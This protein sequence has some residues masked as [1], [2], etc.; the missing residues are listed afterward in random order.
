M[1][2]ELK[3]TLTIEAQTRGIDQ[4]RA[5]GQALDGL[6]KGATESNPGLAKLRATL[7]ELAQQQQLIAQFTRLK[8]E[9]AATATE[10]R[11]TQAAVASAARELKAKQAATQAAAAAEQVAAA[12]TAQARAHHDALK[13]AVALATDELKQLRA[14]ARN[15]GGA[16]GDLAE[17]IKTTQGQLGVLRGESQ[18]AGAQVKA[19]AAEQRQLGA[20]TRDAATEQGVAEKAMARAVAGAQNAKTGYEAQRGTLHSLRQA[21]AQTGVSTTQLADAQR[22]IV[23]AVDQARTAY[24]S[25]MATARARGAEETRLAS[26]IEATKARMARAAQEQLAAEKADHAEAAAAL[27]RRRQQTEAVAR[28]IQSA[29]DSLRMRSASQIQAEIDGVNHSLEVLRSTGNLS[30]GELARASE[31]AR[32]RVA[33]LNREM[34]GLSPTAVRMRE[35]IE[36]IST[37][38][39]RMQRL[40]FAWQGMMAAL[41]RGRE[42]IETADRYKDIE[43]RIDLVNRTAQGFNVTMADMVA[44]SKRTYSGIEGTTQ[45]M[46]SLARAGAELDVGQ[47]AVLRLTETINKANQVAGQSAAAADAAVVQL[48][49]GLQSGVLRGE[50]FN[51]MM[52]QSPRLAKALADGLDVPTSALRAMAGEG[53]LTTDVIIEALQSQ[54]E[55]IDAEFARLPLTVGRALTVLRTSWMNFVGGLD[56]ASGVTAGISHL[57]VALS[58]NLE[59]LGRIVAVVGE[60]IVAHFA[61]KAV[62]G[63]RAYMASQVAATAS[64]G[65]LSAAT[66]GMTAALAAARTAMMRFLPA[67]I[68]VLIGELIYWLY[69]A[70]TGWDELKERARNWWTGGDKSTERARNQIAA[71]EKSLKA[72]AD[73]FEPVAEAARDALEDVQKRIDETRNTATTAAG[74][75]GTAYSGMTDLLAGKLDEQLAAIERRYEQERAE[76]EA[77]GASQRALIGEGTRLLTAALLAET[78]ARQSAAAETLRLIDEEG[79]ARR[80]AAE[81]QADTDADRQVA[82]RRVENEI[83]AT[84]KGA[85]EQALES[86]RRHVDALNAE[87][88]RHLAEVTRI[89][90]AKQAL[91]LSVEDR[92]R[93]IQRGTMSEAEALEDRRAQVAEKQAAARQALSQGE[94]DKSRALA[95]QAMELSA[96]VAGAQTRDA[97]DSAAA[98]RTV[99][100]AIQDMLSSEKLMQEALDAEAAAHRQAAEKAGAARTEIGRTISE[101]EQQVNA[102]AEALQDGLKLTLE[103]DTEKLQKALDEVAALAAEKEVLVSVEADL[104]AAEQRIEEYAALLA[105]GKELPVDADFSAAQAALERF[106]EWAAAQ[107]KVALE[108]QTEDAQ[109]AIEKVQAGIE[110]LA[111]IRTESRHVVEHNAAAVAGEI[112]SLNG[113][114]THSTHTITIQRVEANAAG[115]LIGRAAAGV[116][117]L[118]GGGRAWPWM[119]EGAVPG[120]GD[121]DSVA[122]TLPAG[123]YVVRKAAVAHYGRSGLQDMITRATAAAGH[124]ASAARRA[125]AGVSALLMPGEQV[126]APADVARLGVQFFDGLNAMTLPPAPQQFAGGGA[127]TPMIVAGSAE[128]DVISRAWRRLFRR[129][130]VTNPDD[131]AEFRKWFALLYEPEQQSFSRSTP[132]TAGSAALEEWAARMEGYAD[133]VA[134][135]ALG[136]MRRA[137]DKRGGETSGTASRS[138]SAAPEIAVRRDAGDP[139]PGAGATAGRRVH[140]VVDLARQQHTFD[141]ASERD[142][143]AVEMMLRSLESAAKV[144]T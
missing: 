138:S 89:E 58:N 131:E 53:K 128:S 130:A 91:R 3:T 13:G 114:D 86:Y 82:A 80:Q 17:R 115:G 20:A 25:A 98:K 9:T 90:S 39:A 21:L 56:K 129:G 63:L 27:E 92:I 22:R 107:G 57:I 77:S 108:I 54:A 99:D 10:M 94:F 133:Q 126:I 68:I 45:L 23:G 105:A 48:I 78:T 69:K 49:Q 29:L 111:D 116:L 97:K 51:S 125:T 73:R 2:R 31:R 67:A 134:G 142:A 35:G 144:A 11:Q 14:E 102:L 71:L 117:R 83:L 44:L 36:S 112:D 37:S 84:R 110:K 24:I 15:A 100:R 12:A 55:A 5:A 64:T 40:F 122:R 143:S 66:M 59:T 41:A 33:D 104:T 96:Q 34:A 123:A 140:I 135:E 61:V 127:V 113:R 46:G 72:A 87:A 60:L 7:G 103:A 28:A 70:V 16:S 74:D 106:G 95:Q 79:A 136:R 6:G 124:I 42:L 52:E 50:E 26:I 85:L 43:A 139:A 119:T 93:E 121:T 32:A 76:L 88:N 118:A 18:R 19:L 120:A 109:M 81:A 62:L 1:S 4:I 132:T 38:M 47:E 30:A 101:T 65:V 8:T 141:V 75:I 137:A